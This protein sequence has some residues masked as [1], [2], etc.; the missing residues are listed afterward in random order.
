MRLEKLVERKIAHKGH[1]QLNIDT[2]E[3]PDGTQEIREVVEHKPCVVVIPI[4]SNG[5]IYLV[6]QYRYSVGKELTELPAGGVE[7]GESAEDAVRRE[8]AEEIGLVPTKIIYL[9]DFYLVPGYST[10]NMKLYIA[11][12]LRPPE[13]KLVAEDTE[14]IEVLK[15]SPKL[16]LRMIIHCEINDGKTIAGA[17]TYFA[18]EKEVIGGF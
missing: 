16:L 18:L 11:K 8:L 15:V 7:D 2:V 14:G 10:E 9:T 5:D 13:T 17:L 12:G 1:I 3:L 4:D 6:K